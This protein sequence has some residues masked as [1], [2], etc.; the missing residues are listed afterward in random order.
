MISASGF[1]SKVEYPLK[2]FS[3]SENNPS[4]A[5]LVRRVRQGETE[6][7]DE[8]DRRYRSVLIRFL[9][10]YTFGAEQAE[11]YCQ[12]TLVRALE[13]IDQL[14]SEDK[15]VGWLHRIALRIAA[16]EG[17]KRKPVSLDALPPESR[18]R[19]EPARLDDA[20]LERRER[21]EGLWKIAKKQL[22]AEELR[23]LTMRYRDDLSTERIAKILHKNEGAVRVQ[24]HRIRRKLLP[25]F[26]GTE[27]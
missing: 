20:P 18:Q 14:Q 24:L 25:F 5:E 10:R 4:D 21:Q 12:Q 1:R 16:A 9:L 6:A 22:T 11:E 7:F 26:S 2:S 15:L 17:R 3:D 19:L 8:I 23:I 13:R 27:S